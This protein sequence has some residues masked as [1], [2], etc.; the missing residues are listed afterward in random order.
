[1]A[2]GRASGRRRSARFSADA[3]H[4][5]RTPLTLIRLNAERLREHLAADAEAT[6]LVDNQFETIAQETKKGC[7]VGKALAAVPIHLSARLT[8]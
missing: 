1:M 5:L 7:P 3:S 4:E 2:T 8:G 6:A